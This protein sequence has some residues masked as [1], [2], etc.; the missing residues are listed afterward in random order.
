M[1][2]VNISVV[3]NS[4]LIMD[5]MCVTKISRQVMFASLKFRN[6]F[7]YHEIREINVLREFHVTE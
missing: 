6:F 5:I 2:F 4:F 3:I 1:S 7:W